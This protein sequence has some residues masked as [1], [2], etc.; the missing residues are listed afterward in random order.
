MEKNVE[1]E[2]LLGVSFTG[3]TTILLLWG[4]EGLQVLA[5]RLNKWRDYARKTNKIWADKIGNP[6]A[7]IVASSLVEPYLV[8]AIPPLVFTL[9]SHGITF[10]V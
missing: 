6:S 10:V 8:C 4:K 2:R 1:E 7:A 3:I 5:G 9:D